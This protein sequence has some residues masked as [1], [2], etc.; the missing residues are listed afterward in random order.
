MS[1]RKK[2]SDDKIIQ[3]L[4]EQRGSIKKTAASLGVCRATL[5]NW[6]NKSRKLQKA[7][8]QINEGLV[9]DLEEALTLLALGIQEKN[10]DGNFVGWIKTPHFHALKLSLSSKA[11]DRGYGEKEND[12]N[13]KIIIEWH[14]EKWS[15]E[16]E[17]N[18]KM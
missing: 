7:R 5:Y 15:D 13:E 2:I 3:I 8:K 4:S 12:T 16:K 10:E 9:D 11:K 17:K 6:I 18:E 1:A 14:E